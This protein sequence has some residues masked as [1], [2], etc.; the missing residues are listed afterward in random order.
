MNPASAV[1]RILGRRRPLGDD[2]A[3]EPGDGEPG[4]GEPSDDEPSDDAAGF[5]GPANV[6]RDGPVF[7]SQCPVCPWEGDGRFL[8]IDAAI[9]TARHNTGVHPA[10]LPQPVEIAIL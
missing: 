10:P 5:A 2:V 7:W 8:H 4:D 3:D 1:L 6:L 9:D